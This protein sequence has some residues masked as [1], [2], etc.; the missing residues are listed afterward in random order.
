[1]PDQTLTCYRDFIIHPT[2]SP[3]HDEASAMLDRRDEQHLPSCRLL[4]S[5]SVVISVRC[6]KWKNNLV[7]LSN[8]SNFFFSDCTTTRQT[9]L[10]EVNDGR[11][12]L[13]NSGKTSEENQ[14][15]GERKQ[16]ITVA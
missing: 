1:M 5:L 8:V 13:D 16:R 7:Q 12:Y 3:L 15:K 2:V 4:F 11:D 10:Y 14:E 6:N 9:Y